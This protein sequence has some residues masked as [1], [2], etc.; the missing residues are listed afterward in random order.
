MYDLVVKQGVRRGAVPPGLQV[1]QDVDSG[2]GR[3]G[4]PPQAVGRVLRE[5][6]HDAAHGVRECRTLARRTARPYS[7]AASGWGVTCGWISCSSNA[8][9]SLCR[10][11]GS[12]CRPAV[13]ALCSSW[14]NTIRAG[15]A[16]HCWNG[17]VRTA[18][19]AYSRCST[20]AW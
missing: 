14:A 19:W 6:P 12:M 15:T 7:A 3:S 9:A 2:A 16:W 1:D 20:R 10:N 17:A 13:R 8:A 5:G 18:G 4:D 11:S